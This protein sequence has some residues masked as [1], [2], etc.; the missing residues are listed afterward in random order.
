MYVIGVDLGT[1]SLKGLLVDPS[2]KIVA[3]AS[4]A[5][6]PIYPNPAWA[7]QV[8]ADWIHSFKK[9]VH[10]LLDVSGVNPEEIGTIG[11]D[12]IND[13]IV[14]IDQDGNPMMNSIIWLDRRAENEIKEVEQR[15]SA[16]LF[17]YRSQDALGK[18]EP[19]GN[20]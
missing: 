11:M 6:D 8:V 15:V 10:E 2:G 1:Q 4:C 19:S 5:H 3:E 14:V 12:A 9:V 17:S 16:G 7:E 20:F 13:S 18:E